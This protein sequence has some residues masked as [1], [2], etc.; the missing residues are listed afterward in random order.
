MLSLIIE[1]IN[2]IYIYFDIVYPRHWQTGPLCFFYLNYS[3][4]TISMPVAVPALYQYYPAVPL[5]ELTS[6]YTVGN[7][8]FP[9][10]PAAG[11]N[12]A[13][14][15]RVAVLSYLPRTLMIHDGFEFN[16]K[17]LLFIE[18]VAQVTSVAWSVQLYM[19]GVQQPAGNFLRT[20]DTNPFEF[21]IYFKDSVIGAGGVPQFDRLKVTCTVVNGGE[22]KIMQLDHCFAK[23]TNVTG[24]VSATQCHAFAGEPFTYN[25][26]ANQLKE[27]FADGS[28]WW[29]GQ[30]IEFLP[31]S[32]LMTVLGILYYNI[33]V[34]PAMNAQNTRSFEWQNFTRAELV[35]AINGNGAYTGNFRI[36]PGMIPLHVLSD[37]LANINA[38]PDFINIPNNNPIYAVL[39]SAP[40]LTYNWVDP[41]PPDAAH[42]QQSKARLMGDRPRL[43]ALFHYAMFPKSAIRMTA[44]LVKFL[45]ECSKKNNFNECKDRTLHFLAATLATHK[46]TPDVMR[47]ILTHYYRD[48]YNKIDVYAPEALKTASLSWSPYTYSLVH[49]VKPRILKAYFARRVVK[50]ISNDFYEINFERADSM[51]FRNAGGNWVLESGAARMDAANQPIPKPAWDNFLGRD[52]FLV[53]DTWC[54]QGKTVRCNIA[55][56]ANTFNVGVTN[57]NLQV[58]M[59]GNYIYD[60]ER[61]FKQYAALNTAANL[62]PGNNQ[63]L[64]TE[65][66]DVNHST[67]FI[68][69]I[70]LRP[71][72]LAGFNAWTNSLAS[73]TRALA[74]KAKLTDDTIC[75][76]GNNTQQTAATATFLDTGDPYDSRCRY[77]IIN[78]L[79][80]EAHHEQDPFN[81][82][83]GLR[84]GK[85]PN[86]F[87]QN[88]DN[89]NAAML[90][91]R[92]AFFI[93]I[94]ELGHEHYICDCQI[95]KPKKRLSGVRVYRRTDIDANNNAQVIDTFLNNYPQ[96]GNRFYRTQGNNNFI[97]IDTNANPPVQPMANTANNLGES[98]W[99]YYGSHDNVT[100]FPA[101]R[102]DEYDQIVVRGTNNN[103]VVSFEIDTTDQNE[104]RVEIVRMPD[105]LHHTYTAGT[106]N[107][108][109]HY[110][111]SNTHR[112]FANPGCFAAFVGILAYLN[113]ANMVSTGM[114]FEDATSYPSVSH[115][116]GD[117]IDTEHR[118][119]AQ[120]RQATVAQFIGWGFTQ[121]ISG[122]AAQYLNDGAHQ[123]QADHNS[124]LHSGNFDVPNNVRNI[125]Q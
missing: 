30:T 35:T 96:N 40:P 105:S 10:T 97:V 120:E 64:V 81:R 14:T 67:K 119:T 123:H 65:Y 83:G 69:R 51:Q 9:T 54:C 55:A 71:D 32:L 52:T 19:D 45:F 92:K 68:A 57:G 114:C 79:V 4:K 11:N 23:A 49:D 90:P 5:K 22:T 60:I 16:N 84:I 125:I 3:T 13:Q 8:A 107:K 26:M 110:S 101:T 85:I 27:Y 62:L 28:L 74:I 98:R 99:K 116:N 38:V 111:F 37:A 36:G 124:H 88:I 66:L 115:P 87:V 6:L 48:P 82:L 43:L 93:Y 117:S 100:T 70:R 33:Q 15:H 91:H 63:A 21:N 94:D 50:K 75:F 18:A 89:A 122:N 109:I 78:R 1:R 121:V 39:A 46:D 77:N 41:D 118:N 113:Y 61:Q 31:E 53:V 34:S 12:P 47:N 86:D 73:N 112:R 17:Y 59:D 42:V 104:L 20:V 106:V 24:L 80:Y 25:F 76:F 29:N 95:H 58:E 7:H 2:I 103:A 108:M 44:I 56:P 72:S 102:M